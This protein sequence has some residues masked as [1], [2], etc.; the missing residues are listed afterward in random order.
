MI[1]DAQAGGMVDHGAYPVFPLDFIPGDL[2][3][4]YR[5]SR[6][7]LTMFE[8]RSRGRWQPE[9]QTKLRDGRHQQQRGDV[10]QDAMDLRR[11][12]FSDPLS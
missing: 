3:Y 6:L 11:V 8:R 7:P 2:A 12:S 9:R 1:C 4:Q 5:L 10:Q